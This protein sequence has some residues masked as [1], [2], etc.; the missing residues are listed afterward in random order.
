MSL[1]PLA[2]LW[3]P[4]L[5]L[6]LTGFVDV[7]GGASCSVISLSSHVEAASDVVDSGSLGAGSLVALV[8]GLLTV[9]SSVVSLVKGASAIADVVGVTSLVVRFTGWVDTISKAAS[10]DVVGSGSL[11]ARSW[12]AL[13]TGLLDAW[14]SVVILAASA[15]ADV[16]L[17]GVGSLGAVSLEALDT[18]LLAA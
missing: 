18:G 10:V 1:Q 11:G 9:F 3:L 2:L 7:I 8:T 14:F 13:V 17:M 12:V 16:E 5:F 4:A 15:I 6:G